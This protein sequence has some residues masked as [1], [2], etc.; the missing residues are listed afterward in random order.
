MTRGHS[1]FVRLKGRPNRVK[2]RSSTTKSVTPR[3]SQP[4]EPEVQNPG[5]GLEPIYFLNPIG[6]SSEF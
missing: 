1:Y 6:P 2:P 5:Y 3:R 4:V